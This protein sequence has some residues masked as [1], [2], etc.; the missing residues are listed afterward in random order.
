MAIKRSQRAAREFA[1][2]R[3]SA[4]CDDIATESRFYAQPYAWRR[5]FGW[6]DY[7][8][9]EFAYNRADIDDL[10][11]GRV[12]Y[13]GPMHVENLD[14]DRR[15]TTATGFYDIPTKT[16]EID[17]GNALRPHRLTIR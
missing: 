13:N 14:S 6:F 16:A 8:K 11:A 15:G 7:D 17:C 2:R 10:R 5:S 12:R 3:F 4:R 9:I 1:R